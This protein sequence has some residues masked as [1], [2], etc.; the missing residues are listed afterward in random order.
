MAN[1]YW[2]ASVTGGT[3]SYYL[4]TA[5]PYFGVGSAVTTTVNYPATTA[6]FSGLTNGDTYLISVTGVNAAG[7]S[8]LAYAIQPVTPFSN[9]INP[10][11][12]GDP[13]VITIY[14]QHYMLPND[15]KEV[16]MLTAIDKNNNLY[17]IQA[18]TRLMTSEEL[19]QKK[20]FCVT[21]K[22]HRHRGYIKV[23]EV[24]VLDDETVMKLKEIS[25]FDKFV[26]K[27]NDSTMVVDGFTG[28]IETNVVGEDIVIVPSNELMKTSVGEHYYPRTSKLRSFD[29]KFGLMVAHISVDNTYA[30]VN[31]TR[32]DMDEQQFK[33]YSGAIITKIY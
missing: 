31:Y 10:G 32:F 23:K 22:V 12:G 13:H 15:L 29:I 3:P 2:T 26:I 16:N 33:K 18:T 30:D 20:A 4:L 14:G 11:A 17:S 1:V 24:Q 6:I 7:T 27:Y 9:S 8:A 19:R 21:H 25:C 28:E 5:E